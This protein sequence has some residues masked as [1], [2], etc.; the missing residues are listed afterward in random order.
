MRAAR[1]ARR[2]FAKCLS[3]FEPGQAPSETTEPVPEQYVEVA[4]GEPARQTKLA[5]AAAF[6]HPAAERSRAF[7]FAAGLVAAAYRRLQ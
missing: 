5:R 4:R 6:D 2:V 7:D 1:R 3:P